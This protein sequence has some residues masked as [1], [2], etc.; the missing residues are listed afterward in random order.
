MFLTETLAGGFANPVMESQ[1]VFRAVMDGFSNPG[2]V[3]IATSTVEAP[4]PLGKAAASILLTLC[5]FETD[6]W[7]APSISSPSIH[8]WVKF[9]A[10]APLAAGPNQS[11]FAFVGETSEMPVLASFAMG[12]DE[13]PDTSTTVVLEIAS[14]DGGAPLLLE[15]PGIKGRRL[16]APRGLPDRLK[17]DWASNQA[18]YPCGI[19]LI[20]TAGDQFVCL[21]RTTRIREA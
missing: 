11:A 1:A 4:E 20:L 12:N 7:L 16:F 17:D 2:H 14:L 19:D 5:D 10:G 8:G 3:G 18:S 13:Y 9:N 21:P 15:G 6:V